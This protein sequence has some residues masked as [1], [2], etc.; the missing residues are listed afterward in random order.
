MDTE[1]NII[2]TLAYYQALG[3]EFLTPPEIKRYLITTSGKP[4]TGSLYE[5]NKTLESLKLKGYIKENQGFFGLKNHSNNEPE[6]KYSIKIS[7]EKAK[8][9][10]R[11]GAFLPYIPFIEGVALM[12]SVASFNSNQN[13]DIDVSISCET[14]HIWACRLLNTAISQ[15]LGVRRNTKKVTDRLCFNHYTSSADPEE[16]LNSFTAH[17]IKQQKI[18]VWTKEGSDYAHPLLQLKPK[19]TLLVLKS[20]PE[21][22]LG[23]S[24]V[25]SIASQLQLKKISANP[26]EYPPELPK[27]HKKSTNLI[28]YY[29]KVKATESKHRALINAHLTKQQIT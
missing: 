13:S 17:E 12:G 29:P 14:H 5:I 15:V 27:P 4:A 3:C 23:H 22:I 18:T 21:K 24:V 10:K 16:G 1:K 7:A 25:E 19:K 20:I 6:R 26:E 28:F 2:A 8:E 11:K 9:F